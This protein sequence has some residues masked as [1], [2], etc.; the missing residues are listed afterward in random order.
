S[1]ES[2][3]TTDINSSLAAEMNNFFGAMQ[4]LSQ[5]PEELTT[6]TSV[7]ENA[8]NLGASFRRIDLELRRFQQGMNDKIHNEIN[9]TNQLLNGIARLNLEIRIKETDPEN[10]ANDLRDQR[11]LMVRKLSE[12]LNLNYYEDNHGMLSV[13]GPN[14][15]MLVDKGSC[16]TFA[17]TVNHDNPT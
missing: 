4:D 9:D 3:Y 11:D 8:L 17:T 15:T 13:H 10:L 16:S 12:K 1:L 6:R 5:N 7:R 14:G 2:I